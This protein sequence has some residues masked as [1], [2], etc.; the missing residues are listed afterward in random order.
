[1][2]MKYGFEP[3]SNPHEIY[4]HLPQFET[5]IRGSSHKYRDFPYNIRV[6]IIITSHM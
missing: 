4:V 6:S 3:T 2:Q 1:M 5:L